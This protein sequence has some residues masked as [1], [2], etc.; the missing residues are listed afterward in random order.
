[1]KWKKESATRCTERWKREAI[2]AATVVFPDPGGPVK[3]KASAISAVITD[4]RPE[5]KD[6]ESSRVDHRC[7]VSPVDEH[8]YGLI[9]EHSVAN[10]L[11]EPGDREAV[12]DQEHRCLWS[13]GH[14]GD[15]LADVLQGFAQRQAS[16]RKRRL[17][18][19]R[20]LPLIQIGVRPQL[21]V[22]GSWVVE[23][24]DDEPW[25]VAPSEDDVRRLDAALEV[26][27]DA[28]LDR[29]AGELISSACSLLST[30]R[31][32]TAGSRRVPVQH[33]ALVEHALSV[34]HHDQRLHRQHDGKGR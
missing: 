23:L 7:N 14:R 13:S 34:P 29:G 20:L 21:E 30:A 16:A 5:P 26:R 6:V 11:Q 10:R 27:R 17:R 4:V 19:V 9:R 28:E 8:G 24:F 22:A 1:M 15:A 32:Q 3:I 18:P 25:D 2:S 33:A 31:C 12:D